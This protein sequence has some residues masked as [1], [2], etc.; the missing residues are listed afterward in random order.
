M[1]IDPRRSSRGRAERFVVSSKIVAVAVAVAGCGAPAVA[2]AQLI[3]DLGQSLA[4]GFNTPWRFSSSLDVDENWSDNINLSPAGS[5]RSDFVT[6]INPSFHMSRNSARLSTSLDYTPSY[7]WYANHTNGAALRNSLNATLHSNV[8]ENLLSFD[9]TTGIAQQNVSPFG[10]QAANTYNGSQNRVEG[11][12]FSAGPTLQSRLQQ[13]VTYSLGYRYTASSAGSALY[14]ASHTNEEFGNIQ[15]STSFRDVG[16][17]VQFDRTDQVY[18]QTNELVTETVNGTLT[19][20]L[21]PTVHLHA[22]IGYDRDHYPSTSIADLSGA[23]YSAGFDWNPSHH[24]Q[25][26]VTFGHRYFG[27]TANVSLVESSQHY[28]INAIYSRD[29]T[30]SSG[31]GLA[32]VANPNYQL[33]D[34]Y[35]RS[36][37]TDPTARAAAVQSVLAQAGLSTSPYAT[38]SFFSNQLYIQKRAELSVALLG[39][40]NTVT[41]DISRTDVQGLSA[42]DVGFDIFNQAQKF[43]TTTY[44]AN[45]SYR[46]GPRTSLNGTVQKND[47]HALVG[48]G[49]SRQRVLIASINRQVSKNVSANAMYR[50]TAQDSDVSTP[51]L[52]GGNY[53]ENAVLAGLHVNF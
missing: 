6:S 45:W 49:D 42:F 22:S 23:S 14:A 3:G 29:Q 5:Q 8:I 26:S 47:S 13:D 21:V 4:G 41:F 11:R 24:T 44:T 20:V 12:T 52:Y 25:V 51:G 43:R 15:T 46:L 48:A 28:T 40:R 18:N 33:L 35:L 2:S 39:L 17:G 1:V 19:Y 31:S 9:A 38:T 34:Q 16:V 30:T 10:T 50:N 27:P 37:I 36:Q 7:L 32:A 53:R